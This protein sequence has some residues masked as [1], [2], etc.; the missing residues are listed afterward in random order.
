MACDEFQT[1]LNLKLKQLKI[2]ESV[3]GSYIISILE[4]E[5]EKYSALEG[6]FQELM[7]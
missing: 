1:W 7:V 6:L 3:F 4:E 2:D 5:D